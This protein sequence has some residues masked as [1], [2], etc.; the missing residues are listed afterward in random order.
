MNR[1][2]QVLLSRRS[3]YVNQGNLWEFPGGKQIPGEDSKTALYREIFEEIGLEI[4]EARPLIKLHH[5]YPGQPTIL[6]VWLVTEWNGT[7]YS[8]EGQALK[9]VHKTKLTSVEFPAANEK[10]IS[11]LQ[12]PRLY[13]ISPGPQGNIAD[14]Y[15]GIESCIDAG[16]KLLQ[17]RCNEEILINEPKIIARVLAICR[18]KNARLLL[19]SSPVKC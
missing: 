2:E 5:E 19:N 3:K 8:K 17:L 6:N 12:L 11:T 13:L 18:D 10:I 16:A 7:P 4:L 1:D 15:Y 14:F 9:W